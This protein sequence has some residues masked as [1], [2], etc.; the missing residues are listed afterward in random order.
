MYETYFH[1][2]LKPFAMSPDPAFLYQSAQHSAASTMLEY[3]IE[4][5]APF[6]LLTGEIG[7]GKTTL[8]RHFLR[9]LGRNTTVGL[10]SNTHGRFA[11]IY[12]W[13]LSALGIA[14]A[15]D[16]DIAQYEALVDFFVREYSKGRRT[17]LVFDEAHNLS[18]QILEELRLLSNVNSE[19]D[20]ALQVFLVGQPELRSKLESPELEQFAQR[21]SVDFHLGSLTPDD[22]SS[23]IQHR[24][25]VAGGDAA[26][27]RA[28]AI[29]FIHARTRGIPRLINQLCDMALLYAYAE[30]R[31]IVDLNL[32]QHVLSD[33]QQRGA[34]PLFSGRAA[35]SG[36]AAAPAVDTGLTSE[37]G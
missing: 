22:T 14:P 31:S 26:L 34:M 3:A 12:P 19:S 33:R 28:E 36:I 27:F 9:R 8:L 7:S 24:L 29:A 32:L 37:R 13:A 16:S 18:S 20:L 1:F 11:S 17:L 25:T 35:A 2:S 6:C 4:S 21:V 10:I 23:Y 5:Q 15:D 30:Q